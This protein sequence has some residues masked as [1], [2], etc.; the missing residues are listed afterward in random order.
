[1]SQLLEKAERCGIRKEQYPPDGLRTPL[2]LRWCAMPILHAAHRFAADAM[3]VDSEAALTDILSD[4]C[5]QIGCNWYALSHHVDFLAAPWKGVRIHNYP[6]EWA[7]WF[8]EQ[9]LGLTDPVHRVSQRRVAG[10]LW[11]DMA[12]LS[13]PRPEDALILRRA[14]QHGIY[15]G[16]TV[17]AHL[18][19]EAHGSVTFAW[20]DAGGAS[21]DALCFAQMIGGFAF[22]AARRLAR[23]IAE[24]Q[25]LRPRLTRRQ[26]ECVRWAARGKSDWSIAQILGLSEDTVR[27]HLR[28]ARARYAAPTRTSLVIRALFDGIISF[29]DVAEG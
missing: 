7:R 2:V 28:H 6:E 16:L 12:E 20:D 19:G 17:P 13:A 1:M 11:Q 5:T 24:W 14:Q 25:G 26:I 8:D 22:E 27:E 10:F 4:A 3:T 23:P 29:C 9:R 18:P 15:D 21:T